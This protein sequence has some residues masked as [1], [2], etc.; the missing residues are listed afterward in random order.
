MRKFMLVTTVSLLVACGG[1][2]SAM[3]ESDVVKP[4]TPTATT[5]TT[6]Y[7]DASGGSDSN[8]GTSQNAAWKTLSPT[9]SMK[10][11]AG[12]QLLLKC[13]GT[14][15]GVLELKV[16]GTATAPV[17]VGS[18]GSGNLPV[19]QGNDASK[20]AVRILNSDYLTFQNI[21]IVNT[22]KDRLAGRTGLKIE[23][24][25]YGVSRNIKIN[26]VTVRDVNGS[27]VKEKGGGCGIL[28]ENGGTSVGSR[29]DSLQIVNC[30][31]LRCSRN[32][33]I[34]N[35]EYYDRR[36]WLAS[37]N[38]II[39]GNLIEQV[40]GDGIVPIGCDNTLIEYN[41]MR[42]CPETL[43]ST[44]AAAGFWPWSCDNT[45]IQFNEVSGHKAPW[46]GE[47]YDCDY[48][49]RNTVIQYNY[50]HDNYG[51]MV[52]VCDDG[53]ERNYSIGNQNSIVRYNISI[54]D[55]QRPNIT[56]TGGMFSPNI[57]ISGKVTN[58]L[59][60]HNI[61]HS[62]VKTATEADRTMITSDSWGGYADYT[63]IRNNVF[64]T[65]E[66]SKF[67][68][69]NSTH[70]TFLHNWYVGTYSSI[71][72]DAEKQTASSI[73]QSEILDKGTTGFA[74]LESMMNKRQLYGI[75][76]YS[77]DKNAIEAFFQRLGQ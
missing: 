21:E 73:Y 72:E 32:A 44:E 70:N 63:T 5:A 15:Q 61:I 19:I 68:M 71:P 14:Y 65:A 28:I 34:W 1:S 33:M 76:C 16:A 37:T 42:D 69:N 56:R 77:V 18:Y 41:V 22:G 39:R 45:T 53:G 49:C 51:G 6:Y 58:T 17:V 47:G 46:D 2:S 74:G 54:G 62:N 8:V 66:T 25:D 26:G 13:G 12:D 24:R 31:I 27:L 67:N 3:D 50:S 23:C 10:M 48:N 60:E 35:S 75:E 40:P 11:K 7:I 38:E 52:L 55:A 64:Y 57:H 30:H 43:P 29:F 9:T 4:G 36:K 59:I 20:Y